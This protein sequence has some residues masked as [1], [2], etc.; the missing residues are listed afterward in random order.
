[1]PYLLLDLPPSC[2]SSLRLSLLSFLTLS[3]LTLPS[4]SKALLRVGPVFLPRG[5]EEVGGGSAPAEL[6]APMAA[7]G[8]TRACVYGAE[9]TV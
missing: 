5:G 6:P 1:M 8:D 4:S 9:L 7:G 3:A 2:P